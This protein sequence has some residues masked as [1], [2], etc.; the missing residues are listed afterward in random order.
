M[1][2]SAPI[3]VIVLLFA[4]NAHADWLTARSTYT[5]EPTTGGRVSQFAPIEL[6]TAAAQPISSSGFSHFRSTLNFG[7]SADNYFRVDKWGEPVQP[8]G[9]FRFPF[10]P[11]STP[12]AN[13]GPPLL[14]S[15]TNINVGGQGFPG[16]GFPGQGF[17][18]VGFP[19][20][21]FPG[22]GFPGVGFPGQGFP[23]A[24][25]GN[26]GFGNPGF[27]NPGN[28]RGFPSSGLNRPGFGDRRELNRQSFRDSGFPS[29]RRRGIV[30]GVV[31]RPSIG[32]EQPIGPL[33]PYPSLPLD[34]NRT[35]PIY[36]GHYPTYRD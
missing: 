21:G 13:W 26:P 30:P 35:S 1:Q 17:P 32:Y 36:D 31:G 23:G 33:T 27:R 16:Q 4:A 2:R 20:Q 25:F 3:V 12:Y 22:Q 19:G 28:L 5:H 11:F 6:P 14:G 29:D 34:V 9:A 10:R 18:G 8:F 24:G 7:T 15:G